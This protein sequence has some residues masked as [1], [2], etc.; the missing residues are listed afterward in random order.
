VVG[1]K[2]KDTMSMMSFNADCDGVDEKGE[3]FE[4]KRR[5]K[6]GKSI[7]RILEQERMQGLEFGMSFSSNKFSLD[8]TNGSPSPDFNRVEVGVAQFSKVKNENRTS[9]DELDGGEEEKVPVP[10]TTLRSITEECINELGEPTPDSE[11]PNVTSPNVMYSKNSQTAVV[12][13]PHF[14]TPETARLIKNNFI[15]GNDLPPSHFTVR[16]ESPL[17]KI[18]RLNNSMEGSPTNTGFGT[19]FNSNN[20]TPNTLVSLKDRNSRNMKK[21]QNLNMD[22]IP[23]EEDIDLQQKLF[24]YIFNIGPMEIRSHIIQEFPDRPV[25]LVTVRRIFRMAS[26]AHDIFHTL[27]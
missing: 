18:A 8:N 7:N 17:E 24:E 22:L 12:I 20:P 21:H 16:G 2:D 1:S 26:D 14:G 10:V 27:V 25:H 9:V 11:L 5:G 6:R 13:E 19:P 23:M 4:V 15:M 3:G